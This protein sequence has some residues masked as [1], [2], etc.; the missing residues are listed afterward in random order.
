MGYGGRTSRLESL[1]VLVVVRMD[2]IVPIVEEMVFRGFFLNAFSDWGQDWP[3]FLLAIFLP[4][5]T[6]R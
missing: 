3:D 4:C 2:L 6:I 1:S 5:C